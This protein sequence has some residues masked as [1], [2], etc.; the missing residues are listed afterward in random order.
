MH[1]VCTA[2]RLYDEFIEEVQEAMLDLL[3]TTTR[4]PTA[5]EHAQRIAPP[6]TVSFLVEL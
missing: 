1:D 2:Q 3:T 5:E 4:P 6:I